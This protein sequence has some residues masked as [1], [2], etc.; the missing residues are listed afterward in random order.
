MAGQGHTIGGKFQEIRSIIDQVN[1]KDRVGV[2]IDT[3]HIFAAGTR[4]IEID[5]NN[6][7]GYDFRT[8]STYEKMMKDFED[9]IGFKYLKAF[10]LNDS[11][12]ILLSF[13]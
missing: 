10:H 12:G 3:C 1:D 8:K 11:K 4:M 6:D 13:F 5:S 2:C 9:V 7:T